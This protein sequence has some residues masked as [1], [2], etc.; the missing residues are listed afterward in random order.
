MQFLSP[1][2]LGMSYTQ[3][4]DIFCEYVEYRYRRYDGSTSGWQSFVRKH[5]NVDYLYSLIDPYVFDAK[6]EL[7]AHKLYID[8]PFRVEENYSRYED[9][10]VKF[11]Q[12]F[13]GD[14]DSFLK[15]TQMMQRSYCSEPSKLA[16]L[17]QIL[18]DDTII[19]VKF[20]QSRDT[21]LEKYPHAKVYTYG[22]GSFGLNLQRYSKLVF[23]DKTFDYAQ[24]DQAEHRIFRYGQ[25]KDVTYYDFT[26][27]VNLE[28]TIDKNIYNKI[29]LLDL[30]KKLANEGDEKWENII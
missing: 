15:F 11:L 5:V 1:K 7:N 6:L 20:L 23:F 22:K 3:F 30:F 13:T 19:F 26:G 28:K 29:T 24:K 8:V 4:K 18:D 17:E 14:P 16:A 9:L 2:I 21:I 10:K 27:N 12:S 25:K